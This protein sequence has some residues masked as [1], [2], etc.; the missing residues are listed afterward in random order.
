M[1]EQPP[2]PP[3]PPPGPPPGPVFQP[4][5]LPPPTPPKRRP[6]AWWFT[7]GG[8]LLALAAACAVVAVVLG[9]Q[10]L[11]TDGTIAADAARHTVHLGGTSEHALFVSD[12]DPVPQCRVFADGAAFPLSSDDESLSSDGSWASFARFTTDAAEVQVVCVAEQPVD[13]RIRAAFDDGHAVGIGL[14]VLGALGFGFLGFVAL[15]IVTVL[16]LTRP[17]R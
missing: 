15:V 7:L 13:V 9:I 10:L 17:K 14:G 3:P 12:G 2:T 11:H 1:T 6:S 4:S 5:Y 8:G 16:F